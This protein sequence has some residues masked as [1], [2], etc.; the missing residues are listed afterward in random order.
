MDGQWLTHLDKCKIHLANFKIFKINYGIFIT[1]LLTYQYDAFYVEDKHTI[2][3][4][5]QN[6]CNGAKH[7]FKMFP[8]RLWNPWSEN[9][10]TSILKT[11]LLLFDHALYTLLQTS[12]TLKVLY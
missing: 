3:V 4:L 8:T 6:N 7:L 11:L 12:V 9:L 2:K 10:K 5:S 1:L